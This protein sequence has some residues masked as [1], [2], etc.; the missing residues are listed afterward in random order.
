MNLG[1]CTLVL[2]IVALVSSSLQA[3]V[4]PGRW[5]KVVGLPR[6]THIV[7][8]LRSAD[9]IEGTY[10]GLRNGDLLVHDLSGSEVRIPQSAV[11]KVTSAK[12]VADSLW[13]GPFIGL[14]IGAGTGAVLGATLYREEGFPTIFSRGETAAMTS[15]VG[16]AIGLTIGLVTDVLNKSPEVL[17]V[18]INDS[19][20]E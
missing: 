15:V 2:V 11:E 17:Y 13:N 20:S 18:A 19:P 12:P 16:A 14:G 8:F 4:I 6:D 1:K 10:Q 7:M 5:E 9:Q 3:A